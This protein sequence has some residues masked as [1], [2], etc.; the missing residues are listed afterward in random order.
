MTPK[1]GSSLIT[2]KRQEIDEEEQRK[3]DLI[4]SF[5]IKWKLYVLVNP[6]FLNE[7]DWELLEKVVD[8]R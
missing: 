7:S 8:N 4:E 1:K 6:S 5:K 2:T 3:I